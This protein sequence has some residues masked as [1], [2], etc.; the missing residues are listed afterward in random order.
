MRKGWGIEMVRGLDGCECINNAATLSHLCLCSRYSSELQWALWYQK[1]NSLSQPIDIPES[2][3][4]WAKA[5]ECQV[6]APIVCVINSRLI[7]FNVNSWVACPVYTMR[8]WGGPSVYKTLKPI[9]LFNSRIFDTVWYCTL[10]QT[11]L[12]IFVDQSFPDLQ[13]LE[14][15]FCRSLKVDVEWGQNPIV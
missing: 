12:K 3:N 9:F 4:G 7:M 1:N 15:S 6:T 14:Q 8:V 2:D 11:L 5:P 13:S 10:S